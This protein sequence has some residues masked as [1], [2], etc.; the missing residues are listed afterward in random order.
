MVLDCLK[1]KDPQ[2]P[3][4]VLHGSVS[5]NLQAKGEVLPPP[6]SK[7]ILASAHVHGVQCTCGRPGPGSWKAAHLW[8]PSLSLLT[9]ILCISLL[10]RQKA[11]RAQY[12]NC[13]YFKQIKNPV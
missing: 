13:D 7:A 2:E 8:L 6:A 11:K 5:Q 4:L 1:E 12:Q 9:K 3:T 10:S